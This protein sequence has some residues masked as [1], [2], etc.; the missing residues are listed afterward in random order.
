M[1][2]PV[3][4]IAQMRDW[5]AAT[6][7]A[8]QTE[9]EVIR[10]VGRAVAQHA[11]RQ[12]RPGDRIL[13]LA[14]KGNNGA[15]AR[16]AMGHLPSHGVELLEVRDPATAQPILVAA[17][18]RKPALIIDGLFGIG[19]NRSLD[20][21]W[22]Q[23]IETINRADI[24]I[25]SID[26]PSGLNADSGA[27]H[28][29]ALMAA[30][31][32]TVGAPKIGLLTSSAAPYVGR[33]EVA[34][35]VG[36][37]PCPARPDTLWT[38]P[39]D[40]QKF[41]P[42]RATGTHKGSFGHLAILAGS[43]GYHGAAVL[44]ARA[45]QRARPGLITLFTT[46]DSYPACAAQLQ[47]VMVHPWSDA[48]G[49]P[50]NTSA[51]LAGPGLASATVP[52]SLRN[53]VVQLWR[54]ASMPVVA[55]ASA[56]EWLPPGEVRP[57]AIRV[58]TP[59]PGEAAR[60][61]NRTS[62]EIQADRVASVRALSARHGNC[63]VVLKGNH[64][65]I[66]RSSGAIGVNSSGNPGLAQGGSGDVLGGFLAGLLAQPALQSNPDHCVRFAVW[67]HGATADHL[68]RVRPNWVVEDLVEALGTAGAAERG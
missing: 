40:F 30:M 33:L 37:V 17:L 66:G 21:A 39:A 61:L 65:L 50:K 10:R 54:S 12:I 22:K 53:A 29:A 34:D 48:S 6:W 14:G 51:I 60:L 8:G 26:V 35:D 67:Q 23:L 41:P 27:V 46:P 28:G 38:L 45:A 20:A 43:L 25:L 3:I 36:L 55:D 52:Q 62:A 63:R 15:D 16:Q 44:A 18:A 64:S 24:P 56:L 31:T 2:L 68:E 4:T 47:A 5:E 1:P 13:I 9:T 19:L 58:I 59:H 7:R 57:D 42:R 11:L 49:L 32:V